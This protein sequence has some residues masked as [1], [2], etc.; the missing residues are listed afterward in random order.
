MDK[1]AAAGTRCVVI[2]HY[3][4]S[5]CEASSGCLHESK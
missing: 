3:N 5:P 1:V 4:G 2:R